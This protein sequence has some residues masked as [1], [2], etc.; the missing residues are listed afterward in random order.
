MSQ[1]K[2][3]RVS[4]SSTFEDWRQST[5]D[6][7]FDLGPVASNV[8][9]TADSL[10][11]ES[12]L[13]DQTKIVVQGASITTGDEFIQDQSTGVISSGMRID[14]APDKK[15]DML[16]GYI[17]LSGITGTGTTANKRNAN[18]VAGSIISQINGSSVT[19]FS[20]EVVSI[21]NNRILIKNQT[22]TFSTAANDIADI[23]LASGVSNIVR[24]EIGSLNHGYVRVYKT[25]GGT[26]T[27]L[28]Q[29][30]TSTTGFHIPKAT[31]TITFDSTA[32]VPATFLEAETVFQ[33]NNFASAAFTAKILFITT[34]KVVLYDVNGSFS[35]SLPLKSKTTESNTIAAALI[36]G[37][38]LIAIPQTFSSI[39]RLNTPCASGDTYTIQFGSAVDAI[40]ELQ[41]DIG[42]VASLS[43]SSAFGMSGDQNNMSGSTDL[44]LAINNL[45]DI[46]GNTTLPSHTTSFTATANNKTV[47]GAIENV[48]TFI[49]NTD[50]S[51][52]ALGATA[53]AQSTLTAALTSIKAFIG[54]T[55]IS[56]ITTGEKITDSMARLHTEIGDVAGDLVS[57]G[58][59][60][61]SLGT[62]VPSLSKAIVELKTA[63][64]GSN[65]LVTNIDTLDAN[66]GTHATNFTADDVVAGIVEIQELL[67]N[68][69]GISN[70]NLGNNSAGTNNIVAQ[71]NFIKGFIGTTS[72][73]GIDDNGADADTITEAIAN[74]HTEIGTA[75]I[76]QADLGDNDDT[77]SDLT[78]AINA[79]KGFIGIVGISGVGG[80]DTITSAVAQ[81]FTDIGDVGSSGA[82]L[83][84]ATG[85]SATNLAGAITEIQADIGNAADINNAA[86]YSAASAV[87]GIT[88]IQGLIGDVTSLD[89]AD[90][91]GRFETANIVASLVE[92]RNAIVGD[93]DLTDT[94]AT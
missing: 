73:V 23:K 37:T 26:V 90:N 52:A 61:D 14:L 17:V 7:S 22:G 75:T 82:T 34:A 68:R 58:F 36:D 47:S 28:T 83:A 71:I 74:L 86:G 84:A 45:H 30:V 10:D 16:A 49:G 21:S 69:T 39:I 32:T 89:D 46:I 41:D 35:T 50:L 72:L 15:I 63:L 62:N 54:S 55:D 77:P 66:A 56:A 80:A 11:K 8:N 85:F 18:I 3:T 81:L 93:N 1:N 31:H 78:A 57:K 6:V 60:D 51:D 9:K 88:E 91:L 53:D 59:T 2:E 24:Q 65:N 64:V 67:G 87:T 43:T 38:G 25:N 70:G 76:S 48:M 94:V 20:A 92:L 42:T 12:R 13:A 4:K 19:T 40:L 29:D 79:I 5:N 27:Q 44:Q 33:G